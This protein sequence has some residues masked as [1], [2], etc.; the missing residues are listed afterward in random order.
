MNTIKRTTE[1]VSGSIAAR[2]LGIPKQT[3]SDWRKSGYGP[4]YY[5]FGKRYYYAWVDLDQFIESCEVD[6]AA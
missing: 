3:L 6:P 4:K 5:K 2:F 1:R